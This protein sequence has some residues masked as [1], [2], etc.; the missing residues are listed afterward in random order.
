MKLKS[1]VIN[2]G[3]TSTKVAIF[4]DSTL[5]KQMTLRHNHEDLADFKKIYDQ[6]DYRKQIIMNFLQTEKLSLENFDFFV[7]RGGLL[8]PL[9]QSGTYLIEEAMI[10]DL[11]EE[12]YGAHASNLGTIL[13][14]EFGKLTNKPAYLVDPVVVDE[15]DEIARV[16][17]LKEIKRKSIF[18]ALNQKAVAKRHAR[19]LEKK[20]EELTMIVCHLGG[21]ISVGLHHL[22]RVIDVNDALGGTGPFSPQRVGSL[23]TTQ[24]ADLILSNKY[25]RYELHKMF[26]G[27]GGLMSYLGTD[28]GQS[29]ETRIGMGDKDAKLVMD[30]MAYQIAKEVGSL[31]FIAPRKVDAIILTGGLAYNTYLINT[32]K[33][34]LDKYPLTIYPGEDEMLSLVEGALRAIK[35]E[36][37]VHLY[38]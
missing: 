22:G 31:Y 2:P 35:K 13:A 34:Y 11:K 9:K 24:L 38:Q 27:Q 10:V 21:G 14:F 26:V 4:E 8:K 20:Y 33:V 25:S 12:K 5:V 28:D 32:L 30:A 37:E 23:P 15:L 17:G 16:S 7:G 36:E 29:I 18:H 6:K 3:S 19:S 1:L